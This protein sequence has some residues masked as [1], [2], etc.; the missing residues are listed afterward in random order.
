MIVALR[1]L[2]S[3]QRTVFETLR[4]LH[5]EHGRPSETKKTPTVR[6]TVEVQEVAGVITTDRPS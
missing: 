1:D 4:R 3:A 2:P 5:R 6:Q